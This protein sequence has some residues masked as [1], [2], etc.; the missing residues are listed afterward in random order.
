MQIDPARKKQKDDDCTSSEST[1]F[2]S[3]TG[4]LGWYLRQRIDMISRVRELQTQFGAPHARDLIRVNQ[5]VRY[6]KDTVEIGIRY[7]SL[8]RGVTRLQLWTDG[9]KG[10]AQADKYPVLGDLLLWTNDAPNTLDGTG[11]VL[12]GQGSK[13]DRVSKSSLHTEALAATR[14]VE[15]A[16][17]VSGILSEFYLPPR[18]LEQQLAAQEAGRLAFPVDLIIDAKCL[19]DLLR[20]AGITKVSD[21]GSLLYVKWLKERYDVGAIRGVCWSSTSDM[22]ADVLTKSSADPWQLLR[23]MMECTIQ[24]TWST[25]NNGRL[26]DPHKGLPPSK[27]EKDEA[28]NRFV[29]A[30]HA[31]GGSWDVLLKLL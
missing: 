16:Q 23:V 28:A 11:L 1:A 19:Y 6:A 27:K 30:L 18:T 20:S 4:S 8:P 10:D 29:E 14:G 25:L 22:L 7:V 12:E 9:A 24:T 31:A 13:S 15:K 5:E 21:E 17:K 2:K 3:S 26:Q